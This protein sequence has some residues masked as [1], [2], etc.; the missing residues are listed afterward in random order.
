MC[1]CADNDESVGLISHGVVDLSISKILIFSVRLL[2]LT[3]IDDVEEEVSDEHDDE[4]EDEDRVA[5]DE[6][7]ELEDDEDEEEVDVD[8]NI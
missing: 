5:D 1:C 8:G 7:E 4:Q 2:L 6:D 3:G